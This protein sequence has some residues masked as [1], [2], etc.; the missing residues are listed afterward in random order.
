MRRT[1][2]ALALCFAFTFALTTWVD[3]KRAPSIP[4]EDVG[5]KV[6]PVVSLPTLE[7]DAV[8]FSDDNLEGPRKAPA[9]RLRMASVDPA[10]MPV[11][12]TPSPV[13]LVKRALGFLIK[14][15]GNCFHLE[16]VSPRI[17]RVV[18]DVARQFG[19]PAHAISCLR[20][21][22][23]N[24]RVNGARASQHLPDRKGVAHAI[25]FRIEGVDKYKLARA[26]RAHPTMQKL[27][28]VG[29]YCGN[30][31]HADDGRKRNWDW[32]GGRHRWSR[33]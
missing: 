8:A 2:A 12:A 27:G 26:V 3:G 30:F 32:C 9:A 29:V 7:H 5:G 17:K 25:D 22:A 1:L 28:G 20:T 33:A 31:I 18:E 23:H 15:V 13:D 16:K 10:N 21:Y 14:P 24:K 11:T 4:G 6:I 19:K